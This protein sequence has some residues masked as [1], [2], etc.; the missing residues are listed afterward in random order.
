MVKAK[1]VYRGY[2]E[3]G[4][5]LC[6]LVCSECGKVLAKEWNAGP[7]TIGKPVATC[8]HFRWVYRSKRFGVPFYA[9]AVVE[10]GGGYWVLLPRVGGERSEEL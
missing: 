1:W 5:E 2:T 9:E 8:K 4:T 6:E 7:A 3:H 10:D